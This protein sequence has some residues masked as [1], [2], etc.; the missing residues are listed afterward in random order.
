MSNAR[1]TQAAFDSEV[2]AQVTLLTLIVALHL[3]VYAE[4]RWWLS[5][6]QAVD[7][8]RRWHMPDSSA[9]DVTRRVMLSS[10]ALPLAMRLAECHSCLVDP[11]GMQA[12]FTDHIHIDRRAD[13]YLL[14]REACKA[15]L[16]RQR[17]GM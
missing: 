5:P 17:D 13:R 10:R 1:M 2:E 7:T 4:T 11:A 9:V 15:A 6:S 16:L 14:I 8:M 3:L 12:T